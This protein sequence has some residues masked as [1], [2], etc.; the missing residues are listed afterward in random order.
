MLLLEW[1]KVGEKSKGDLRIWKT[2]AGSKRKMADYRDWSKRER[3]RSEKNGKVNLR[4]SW[5][6]GHRGNSLR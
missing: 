5:K 3:R 4:E 2:P 1:Q 6:R